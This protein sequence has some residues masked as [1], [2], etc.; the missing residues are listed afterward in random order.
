MS[1]RKRFIDVLPV[2]KHALHSGIRPDVNMCSLTG[3]YNP[4]NLLT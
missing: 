4:V 1:G 2:N 3:R